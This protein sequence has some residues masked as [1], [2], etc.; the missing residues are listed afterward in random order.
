MAEQQESFGEALARVDAALRAVYRGDHR[1]FADLWSHADDVSLLGAF[2]PARVGWDALTAVFPWVA[3]RYRDGTLEIENLVV[4]EGDDVAFT[5][6]YERGPVSID[7]GDPGVS[8]IR[9][10][11][12]YRREGGRWMLV[13]RHGDFAPIDDAPSATEGEGRSRT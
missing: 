7:G 5:V 2:G 8:T 1:P 3:A 9:V 10:T 6:G 4:W 13:H 11:Q 12:I